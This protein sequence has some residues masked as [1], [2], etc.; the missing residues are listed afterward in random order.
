VFYI[1]EC[2]HIPARMIYHNCPDLNN[3]FTKS[4][5]PWE[6]YLT[7]DCKNKKQAIAIEKHIKSMK[8]KTYIENLKKYPEMKEKLKSK[9]IH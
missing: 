9:F 1:G 3:G 8:S 6:V 4:G 2:A 5:I 7:I